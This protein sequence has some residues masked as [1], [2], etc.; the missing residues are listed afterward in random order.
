MRKTKFIYSVLFILLIFVANAHSS[1]YYMGPDGSDS[2]TTTQA[3]VY[4]TPWLTLAHAFATM[5]GSDTLIIKDGTYTGTSNIFTTSISPPVGSSGAY[6]FVKAEN[7]GGAVFDGQS[8][9][10]VFD[11]ETDGNKYWQFEGL[12]FINSTGQATLRYADYVKFLRCGLSVVGS[13][14]QGFFIRESSYVLLEGCYAWG[15]SRYQFDAYASDHIIFRHCVGRPDDIDAGT[16]DP[17]AVFAAYTSNYVLFQNCI[18]IDADQKSAWSGIDNYV[19]PFCVPTTSGASTY[20]YFKQ[21]VALNI[22]LG[23]LVISQNTTAS[24]IYYDNTVLWHIMPNSESGTI[25]IP[26]GNVSVNKCTFGD[27]I[28]TNR[29]A[30]A[31]ATSYTNLWTNNI[32]TDVDS[33]QLFT[34]F[35]AGSDYNSFYGN[36]GT[37]YVACGSPIGTNDITTLDPIWS[38]SNTNGAIKYIVRTESGNSLSSSGS[39]GGQVGANATTLIGTSGTLWGDTGYDAETETSMW[40]FPNEDLIKTKMAAYSSGGV[41][42]A[43]GF[44]AT[45][46]QLNGVD[47][48]T[49]TSYIWEYLGN[50]IPSDIYGSSTSCVDYTDQSS[51]ESGGCNWC[52]DTCQSAACSSGG[53]GGH[54]YGASFRGARLIN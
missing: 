39:D 35:S 6:T 18:A 40:P 24:N 19:G 3:Q 21:C 52:T 30:D 4:E 1:T 7:D 15:S 53:S 44:A 11:I 32:I 26:S 46:T 33:A 28:T 27:Q 51:C 8:T 34:W 36:T 37:R 17:A 25:H 48:K 22:L 12:T 20:V 42:G 38:E 2:Y 50:Q 9:R 43:R 14:A 23:G 31:Y 47:P 5:S 10:S 29:W 49:L 13:G 54:A 45:G 41:S 16:A